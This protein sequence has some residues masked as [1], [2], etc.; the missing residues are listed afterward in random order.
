[1]SSLRS[2]GSALHSPSIN[3]PLLSKS[4]DKK[5][6]SSS[7]SS[8]S[9]SLSS[10]S[11][12]IL[13]STLSLSPPHENIRYSATIRSGDNFKSA[14]EFIYQVF[15]SGN[16]IEFQDKGLLIECWKQKCIYARIEI[17][18]ENVLGYNC[19]NEEKSRR[20]SINFGDLS[21]SV[22]PTKKKQSIQIEVERFGD[23]EENYTEKTNI[24][25]LDP[26]VYTSTTQSSIPVIY[27]KPSEFDLDI[28]NATYSHVVKSPYEP[29]GDVS[30]FSKLAKTVTMTYYNG[31]ITIK[32]EKTSIREKE[33]MCEDYPHARKEEKEDKKI[34]MTFEIDLIKKIAKLA[35]SS[36]IIVFSIEEGLPLR[37]KFE[38]SLGV[39]TMYLMYNELFPD[40]NSEQ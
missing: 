40:E 22:K 28:D 11:S 1:M 7:S 36:N 13:P 32:S 30:T 17:P 29:F 33:C 19:G 15:D 9:S 39:I 18:E 35:K 37:I 34:V 12:L 26:R 16:T 24:R 6:S 8:L 14:V 5:S 27:L 25:I 4:T 3:S 10:L 20:I 21:A 23:S 31:R 38:N 2:P